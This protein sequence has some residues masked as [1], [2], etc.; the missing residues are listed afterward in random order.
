MMKIFRVL[1]DYLMEW[2]A[3]VKNEKYGKRQLYGRYLVFGDLLDPGFLRG[4]WSSLNRLSRILHPLKAKF[5]GL[6]LAAFF[7]TNA[8]RPLCGY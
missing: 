5:H 1:V 4:L 3:I 7:W 6:T 2:D 8:A